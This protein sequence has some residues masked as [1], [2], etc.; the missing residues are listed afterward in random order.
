MQTTRLQFNQG[1]RN[2]VVLDKCM[3]EVDE[4]YGSSRDMHGSRN[5][6]SITV[7]SCGIMFIMVK[8]C[9]LAYIHYYAEICS[10]LIRFF[11]Y[12]LTFVQLQYS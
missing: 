5:H 4:K 12:L 6:S 8:L 2:A 10:V 11:M 1:F 7:I 9:L 3:K